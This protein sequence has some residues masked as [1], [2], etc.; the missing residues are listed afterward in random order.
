MSGGTIL[1]SKS[2]PLKLITKLNCDSFD[3]SVINKLDTMRL[4]RNENEFMV[5]LREKS[6]YTCMSESELAKSKSE[7]KIS[8]YYPVI[9]YETIKKI[10]GDRPKCE[11]DF[12][13]IGLGS[14]GTGVL[15]QVAR[16]TYFKTYM[17]IDYD[18]VEAKNLRNQWYTRE[19]LKDFK[20]NKSRNI[21]NY[22]NMSPMK[23]ITHNS[24]F[25]NVSL[26]CY[27]S[28][29][30]VSGF[31][32]LECR[33]KLLD[34]VTS[35]G[36]ECEYLID[37]R[38]LDHECSIYFVNLKDEKQVT[39]Y[40]NLLLGD[41]AE[42]KDIDK[43]KYIET[44]EQ[45]KE[46]WIKH[47]YDKAGCIKGR[48][49]LLNDDVDCKYQLAYGCGCGQCNEGCMDYLWSLFEETQPKIPLEN[50]ES[51]C[52]KQNFIDIYKYASSFIFAAIRE[53]EGDDPKPF[54]HIEAQ[55][56]VIPTSV[57]IRK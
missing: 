48:C 23:I 28:K 49:D 2:H 31:D 44:K 4:P 14:A 36:F 45:L 47:G 56:D 24:K 53:I 50:E 8:N 17:L 21:L 52:V 19:N 40:R 46:Y 12:T 43:G 15:D 55:T 13:V 39:Y 25:E 6:C 33:L 35:G 26:N 1:K 37:L 57:I 7:N 32:N 16:S 42:F 22:S 38:Y 10:I 27:K 34:L 3:E 29:Y 20:V 30:V 41:I 51:S 54:T 9:D 5:K 18:R 11:V